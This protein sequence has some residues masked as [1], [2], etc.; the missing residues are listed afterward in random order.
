MGGGTGPQ[1]ITNETIHWVSITQ[2][3]HHHLCDKCS[4][5]ARLQH[6]Q[7]SRNTLQPSFSSKQNLCPLLYKTSA[8]L[9]K[10][11]QNGFTYKMCVG[12]RML[13]QA[14]FCKAHGFHSSPLRSRLQTPPRLQTVETCSVDCRTVDCRPDTRTLLPQTQLDTEQVQV[15]RSRGV[16]T[17]QKYTRCIRFSCSIN[18]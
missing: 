6:R 17:D 15:G 14:W 13:E 5:E 11:L 9:T 7:D 16:Q 8:V 3:A 4:T 1:W 2:S 18:I 12:V 10:K